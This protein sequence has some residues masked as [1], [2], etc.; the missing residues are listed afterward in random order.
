MKMQLT[1]KELQV[2]LALLIQSNGLIEK[3]YLP[4]GLS[5]TA[6]YNVGNRIIEKI[7]LR[8]KP[9]PEEP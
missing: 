8:L 1:K 2:I 5:P 7:Q 9:F 6:A 4:S 3:E